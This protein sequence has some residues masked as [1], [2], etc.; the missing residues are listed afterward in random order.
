LRNVSISPWISAIRWLNQL[1]LDEC[2]L[3]CNFD[4]ANPPRL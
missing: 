3:P 2:A 4:A 1:L